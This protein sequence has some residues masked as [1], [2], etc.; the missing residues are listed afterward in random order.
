MTRLHV[1]SNDCSGDMQDIVLGV[2][3]GTITDENMIQE[4]FHHLTQCKGCRQLYQDY[5]LVMESDVHVEDDTLVLDI[6][7]KDDM[8]IPYVHSHYVVQ[9]HVYVLNGENPPVVEIEYPYNNEVIRVKIIYN[10]KAI[11]VSIFCPLH[12]IKI[13]LLTGSR[14]DIA[15]VTNNFAHFS[16]I[17]PG[18]IVLLFDFKKIIKIN[19]T[20]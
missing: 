9:P 10:G 15:T 13:H 3:D 12:G 5:F 17:E 2:A 4:V 16:S 20:V 8:L 14:F 1:H 18:I 7:C 11:D 19:I 6:Q